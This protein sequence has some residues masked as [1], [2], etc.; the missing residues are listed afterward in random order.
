MRDI[1]PLVAP[2]SIAVIGAST[3]PEKSGGILFNNLLHGGFSGSLY[4]INPR[5][6]EVMGCK[7]YPTVG[8]VGEPIDLAYVVLPRQFVKEAIIQCADAGVR[9]ACIITA[10]FSEVDDSGRKDEEELRELANARGILLAGPNTIGMVN[11]ECGMMGSFVNFPNWETGPI[12]LF[13]Q[14]GIFTGALMLQVMSQETQRLPVGKS[15]DVGNKIDV[16]ELDFLEFA[17]S[18]EST[19]VIGFYLESLSN[20]RTFLERA[21]EIA[22]TKP[23]VVLKPG[24][25]EAGARASS[26][27]TGS[28]ATDDAMFD[29]GLRQFGI[30][31][32]QDEQ[33]FVNI[34]RAFA[35]MCLPRGR[36]LA[37]A[38]TSGALGVISTDLATDY[39][40]E[41][42]DFAPETTERLQEILP[43]WLEPANPFDFWIGIDVKGPE[44]AH[45][46]ALG[47]I[48]ADPNS[49]IILCTLLA[50]PNADFPG[51]ANLMRE[52][53]QASPDKPIIMVIYGGDVR[54]RWIK[55]L[56]GLSIPVYT[57]IREALSVLAALAGRAGKD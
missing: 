55:A 31:R 51:F 3:N 56:E 41:L 45:R 34:L 6:T 49:D 29:A 57:S 22:A 42:T 44:E 21:G 18:D 40:L 27:H 4:P 32:A 1:T 2:E 48:V 30:V 47:A 7:A 13:T 16:D 33:E 10:G 15:I 26:S 28:L 54:G 37:I 52:V 24:R 36:R 8:E 14:T 19:K 12:S 20:P 39:G 25:T 17:A 9:A 38:T 53:R 43:D 23:I 35:P 11:A 46:T 50:P 5:A